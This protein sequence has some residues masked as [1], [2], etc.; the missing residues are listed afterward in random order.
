MGIGTAGRRA[1][2]LLATATVLGTVAIQT[3]RSDDS[4]PG[5]DADVTPRSTAADTATFVGGEAHLDLA[6]QADRTV[7]AMQALPFDYGT[8]VDDDDLVRLAEQLQVDIGTVL[9]A[10]DVDHLLW[11]AERRIEVATAANEHL[12]PYFELFG[13]GYG[14]RVDPDDVG[15]LAD[16]IGVDIGTIA[17]PEDVPRVAAAAESHVDVRYPV[18][19]TVGGVDLRQPSE[20]VDL[21]GFHESNHD[22]ARQMEVVDSPTPMMTLETRNRGTGSRSAADVV[23]SIKHV[24]RAPV[25]GTVVRSGTYVLY[26][27]YS[28]DYAVIE[29]DAHPGWEVK[30]LHINGVR[31]FAGDRVVAGETVIASSP[32][33]LPFESQVDEFSGPENWPH[34]HVEVVDPSIPDRPSPG[35]GC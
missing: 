4:V 9:D 24:V 14:S 35:G 21:I 33:P 25:T 23:S 6:A 12:L 5:S 15:R 19:A 2:A 28:D 8:R 26:C 1:V 22:G 18:F 34:V 13:L 32:T 3:A 17:D 29:P 10:V 20:V 27:R 11:T 16:R 31:V 7:A 30:L